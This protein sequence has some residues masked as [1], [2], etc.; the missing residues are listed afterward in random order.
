MFSSRLLTTD[1]SCYTKSSTIALLKAMHDNFEPD[2]GIP[3]TVTAEDSAEQDAF[4]TAVLATPIMQRLSTFLQSKGINFSREKFEEMW[5]G[6][7]SREGS[8]LGSS[9]F[10]HVFLGELKNG[11]SGFHNWAFFGREEESEILNYRGWLKILDLGSV[12]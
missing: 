1:S 2:V 7:Y 3:E 9:G 5:F 11:V 4:V 6:L 10:E 12:S 8:I